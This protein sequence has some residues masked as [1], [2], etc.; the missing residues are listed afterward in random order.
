[1][2][3]KDIMDSF[4]RRVRDAV[5]CAI[6]GRRQRRVFTVHQVRSGAIEPDAPY[7][8][9][10]PGTFPY[11]CKAPCCYGRGRSYCW[12]CMRQIIDAHSASRR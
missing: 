7:I 11:N 3:G 8:E 1:M 5:K 12:P 10:K 9:D 4:D 6:G 2:H